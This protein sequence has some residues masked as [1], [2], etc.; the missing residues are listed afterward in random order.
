MQKQAPSLGRILVMA[1]F[2]L[3][4]FGLLLFLWLAF[5]GPIP[6]QPKGYRFN[7]AF[8]EAAT[9]S[10]EAD[11]RISGVSVGKVKVINADKTTGASDATIQLDPAYA[12]IP[13]NTKA[14]LRQKTLLGETYVELTPGS[15]SAGTVP[16]NGRLPDGAV[17]PTVEL[18]EIFRAFDPKT[19]EAFRVWMQQLALSSQG[20]GRDISDSLGNLAPFAQDTTALLK[21][22]NGQRADVQGVVRDTGEVFDALS[23]RDGQLR[24][25]IANS[26]TV[27]ATTAARNRQLEETFRALPTFERESTLTLA[28]LTEFSKATNPL[29]TQLRPAAR[30]LSPT[31]QDLSKLAPELKAL[32]TNLNPL[33]DASVKGL[34]ATEDFLDELHPLLANFDAPLRQ[35]NPPLL[36]LGQY[37]DELS[38][39]FAN[40]VATT[41]ATTQ[42]GNARVHY[43]RTSNPA[44]PENLAVYP[45]RLPTNRPNPYDFPDA[46]KNLSA[47][48][49]SYE[50]RQCTGGPDPTV[51][52]TPVPGLPIDPT[53]LIPADLA[54]NVQKFFF[55]PTTNGAVAAPACKQQGK[56]PF[57]G[58]VTQY[59]HVNPA[60]GPT[61]RALARSAQAG[62]APAPPRTR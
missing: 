40:T 34:P 52:T 44:N 10:P 51:V 24:S 5:G 11:V 9:L 61:A 8:R 38:A 45:R 26:N 56:F 33:F 29:V 2:A 58:E 31:L 25:L 42:E 50:T 35:L 57:G 62:T 12:P 59:P 14:I 49:L 20:R 28:R 36:G 18:D 3:S 16:E 30:Q 48:L 47:G 7:I 22:L 6:L 53:S 43:L 27:F 54:A 1:G 41:Q 32:F 19:R 13:K 55:G 15:P 17:S 46:F 37:K 39:F 60:T 23:E 4:C 21:I